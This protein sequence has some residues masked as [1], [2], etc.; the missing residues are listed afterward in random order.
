MPKRLIDEAR[1]DAA[2]QGGTRQKLAWLASRDPPKPHMGQLASLLLRKYFWGEIT[3]CK[4]QSIAQAA[5]EDGASCPVL[6]VLANLGEDKN[7]ARNLQ[8]RLAPNVLQG[9]SITVTL[10]MLNPIQVVHAP[11]PLL[12]PHM[13][14]AAL[15]EADV[16]LFKQHILGGSSETI[17]N[18]WDSVS[19]HPSMLNH[20]MKEKQSWRTTFVP[21]S[22]HGDGVAIAG[23]GRP[24]SKSAEV[25]SWSSM[26]ASGST[27]M[28]NYMI[29]MIHKLLC[30]KSIGCHHTLNAVFDQLIWSFQILFD[31]KWPQADAD[32]IAYQPGTPEFAKAG[33]PLA[34][35]YRGTLFIMRGDLE[36]FSN[37]LG[38]EHFGSLSPCFLCRA[39]CSNDDIPWA[40]CR[41]NRAKWM[42]T[43]WSN[44]DW[45]AAKPN[46]HRI[47]R[48]V[49]GVS[50]STVIP[51]IMHTKHLGSDSYFYGS[52]LKLLV[53]DILTGNKEDNLNQVFSEI[54]AEY[55][56][57]WTL[58]MI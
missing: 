51:D 46:R 18:F 15:Y 19:D 24:W 32:G 58:F 44:V 20:P 17:P 10:P 48:D 5:E 53:C 9:A 4:I 40:D 39:N 29:V 13:L 12:L 30:C 55:K 42:S 45:E 56:D 33:T 41:A 54:K 36:Y 52:V 57:R 38:L 43:C 22:L 31:G 47:F 28:K 49:P 50:I 2:P 27:I 34:G 3:A 14:F 25:L 16:E 1:D 8:M 26:L 35:G 6:H 21:L 11:T 23:C 37:T 7:C